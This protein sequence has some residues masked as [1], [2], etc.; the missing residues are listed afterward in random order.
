MKL[1]YI[2]FVSYLL[3]KFLNLAIKFIDHL[4]LLSL[5]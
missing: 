2:I 4:T 5:I 1:D 3:L